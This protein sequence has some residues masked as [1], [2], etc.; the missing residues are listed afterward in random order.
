MVA[1]DEPQI[2]LNQSSNL[3]YDGSLAR[4]V[5]RSGVLAGARQL[6]PTPLFRVAKNVL[7]RPYRAEVAWDPDVR[8][9]VLSELADDSRRL[10]EFCG[11]RHD[12]WHD[13][14]D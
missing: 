4:W 1:P 11:K 7:T 5:R 12:F 8:G 13:E 6:M 14:E 9:N 3:R 10:L 2:A